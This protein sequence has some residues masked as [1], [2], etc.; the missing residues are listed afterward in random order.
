MVDYYYGVKSDEVR[1]DRPYYAGIRSE[2]FY[3]GDVQ[4]RDSS[5]MGRDYPY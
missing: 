3:A 1:V 5:K 2:L 4:L